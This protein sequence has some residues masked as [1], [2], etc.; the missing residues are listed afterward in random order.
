MIRLRRQH[1]NPWEEEDVGEVGDF[2][3]EYT[4]KQSSEEFT[5]GAL[6]RERACS[7][8][9]RGVPI[10]FINLV[11]IRTEK[12][13][14]WIMPSLRLVGAAIQPVRL[15]RICWWSTGWGRFQL[16]LLIIVAMSKAFAALIC[17]C[18][19]CIWHPR[20]C[21]CVIHCFV[22]GVHRYANVG[23]C[24]Q[25]ARAKRTLGF[26]QDRNHANGCPLPD[27]TVPFLWR[28][29]NRRFLKMVRWCRF[30]SV[31]WHAAWCN[32]LGSHV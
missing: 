2:T 5:A 23:S 10:S 21:V 15:C 6:G 20:S 12:I 4:D 13:T 32:L 27:A 11:A 26:E 18:V 22:S 1:L 19:P 8:V 14:Q 30:S 7:T 9:R 28:T 29:F 25:P 31:S 17:L 16:K 3:K 24:L